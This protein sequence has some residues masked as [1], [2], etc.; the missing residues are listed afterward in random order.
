MAKPWDRLSDKDYMKEMFGYTDDEVLGFGLH[1]NVVSERTDELL[2]VLDD[3]EALQ[4]D[5]KEKA[6]ALRALLDKR[7]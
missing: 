4:I 2:D 6:A 1:P 5:V 3:V 7:A